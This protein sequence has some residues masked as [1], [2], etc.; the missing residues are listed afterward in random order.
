MTARDLTFLPW[1]GSDLDVQ[2]PRHLLPALGLEDV[3]EC[4]LADDR[5]P[6]PRRRA[7][8]VR[9][10][11]PQL[12]ISRPQQLVDEAV[13]PVAGHVL[14]LDQLLLHP[15]SHAV[16]GDQPIRLLGQPPPGVVRHH[17]HPLSVGIWH[18]LAP[19]W[20]PDRSVSTS[21]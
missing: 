11:L 10:P 8:L 20:I 4:A 2:D 19:S 17:L 7:V 3:A 5:G 21:L 9:P 12:G 1:G 18:A 15:L 16:Q 6:R 14:I 13:L